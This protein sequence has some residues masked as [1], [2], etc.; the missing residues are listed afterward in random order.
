MNI[1][2][3]LYEIIDDYKSTASDEERSGIFRSFCSS[4]WASSNKRRVY[5]KT[6]RFA[7][8]KDLLPTEPGQVFRTWTEIEYTGCKT[9][10]KETDW[11][12]LIRQKI[13]NLYTRYFD[14][15]VILDRD[16]MDLLSTP[17]RLYYQWQDGMDMDAEE[18]T[19]IID[20]AIYRAG[21]LKAAYQKQKMDLSWNDYKKVVEEFL[22]KAFSHCKS[23]EDYEEQSPC[24]NMYDFMNEDNF[25]I[26]YFCKYLENEMKQWQ[27]KYYGVRNHQKYGRCKL[28]GALFEKNHNRKVYCNKCSE[29]MRLERYKKY[30]QKRGTTIGKS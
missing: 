9:L 6:I 5:T 29:V 25:Y 2:N 16:Y 22:L 8:R 19:D 20:D 23:I 27:K 15:D 3:Y 11:C 21:K 30:N 18:L 7:V 1:D 26:R 14:K 13:N 12:S 17:R 28:C 24:Y 4:I 10:S